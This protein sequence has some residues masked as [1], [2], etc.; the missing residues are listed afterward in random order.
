[1]ASVRLRPATLDDV[2]LLDYWDTQQHVIDCGGA[3]DGHDWRGDI[4]RGADWQEILI[5]QADGRAVGVVVII[6]PAREET[7]YWGDCDDNLRA[8]DIWLG[9]KDDL[10]KGLGG[11]M[12][13]QAIARCFDAPEVTAIIIDPLAENVRAQRFYARHGFAPIERR[14]FGNDDCLVMRLDKGERS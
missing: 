5:G 4:S 12:M 14:I 13:R 10:G 9:E 8:I 6:D 2:K 3:D 1:M 7:H 11:E